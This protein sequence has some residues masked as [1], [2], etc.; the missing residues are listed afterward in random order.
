MDTSEIKAGK[1]EK[2]MLEFHSQVHGLPWGIFQICSTIDDTKP[3]NNAPEFRPEWW[4]PRQY[5]HDQYRKGMAT[6]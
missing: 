5:A 4:Q 6:L 3:I 2:E 1:K